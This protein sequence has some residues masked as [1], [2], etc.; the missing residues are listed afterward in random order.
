MQQ[1]AR[2]LDVAEEAVAEAVAL[3][4]PLDE[5]GDVGDHER[6]LVGRLDDAQMR[7]ERRERVVGDPG[8]RGRDA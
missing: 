8:P 1:Q 7:L 4:S 5:P 2:P 3:V 6:P